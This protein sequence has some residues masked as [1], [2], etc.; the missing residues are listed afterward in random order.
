MKMTQLHI[1][2]FSYRRTFRK[3]YTLGIYQMC[4]LLEPLL[5]VTVILD[6]Q[7]LRRRLLKAAKGRN[8]T[9]SRSGRLKYLFYYH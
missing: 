2:F 9:E 6:P 7:E 3:E 8:K 5:I 4:L 1:A